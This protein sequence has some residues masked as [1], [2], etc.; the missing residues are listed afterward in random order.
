MQA[1]LF[2]MGSL[3]R[4]KLLRDSSSLIPHSFVDVKEIQGSHC[5]LRIMLYSMA[6]QSLFPSPIPKI[7]FVSY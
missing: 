3:L 1:A 6:P 2:Y 7:V 5:K 4:Q